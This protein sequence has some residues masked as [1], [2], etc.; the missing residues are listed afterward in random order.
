MPSQ[1]RVT[2]LRNGRT[3]ELRVNDR[4]PFVASRVIDVSQR[5]A[6]LL[7]FE[8]DGITPVR[9]EILAEQSQR[10]K[11]LALKADKS[12]G[13]EVAVKTAPIANVRMAELAPP[14][15]A[16]LAPARPGAPA[17]SGEPSPAKGVYVQ[18]GAFLSYD[19]AAALRR[20]L[21]AIGDAAISPAED[22]QRTWYRVRIGPVASVSEAEMVKKQVAQVGI[23]D[24]RLVQVPR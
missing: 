1:V 11:L 12:A 10:L 18:A 5:S 4:G 20:R 16:A 24:A 9:V 6:Q 15:A 21:T 22:G 2:N 3:L 23:A 19:N 14:P 8:Q 17:S 7:G 13:Q